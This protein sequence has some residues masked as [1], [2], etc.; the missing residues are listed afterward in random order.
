MVVA[1]VG[2]PVVVEGEDRGGV[3]AVVIVVKAIAGEAVVV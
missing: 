3:T 2:S 1:V